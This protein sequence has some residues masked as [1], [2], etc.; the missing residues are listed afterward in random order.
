MAV[1]GTQSKGYC[2]VEFLKEGKVE[3]CPSN[4]LDRTSKMSWWPNLVT[5]KRLNSMLIHHEIPD[6]KNGQYH[7]IRVMG[8]AGK[9]LQLSAFIC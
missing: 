3:A 2:I 6:E 9:W 4:W 7:P 1:D 8:Q 5:S